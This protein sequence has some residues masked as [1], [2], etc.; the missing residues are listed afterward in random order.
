[1]FNILT[2]KILAASKKVMELAIIN[3]QLDRRIPYINQ[4]ATPIVNNEYM[5]SEIPSV[6]FVLSV[7]IAWGKK[8]PVVSIA[9]KNP[10]YSMLCIN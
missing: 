2:A 1:V 6:F 9:A 10:R 7:M 4:N 5:E 8:E 3:D